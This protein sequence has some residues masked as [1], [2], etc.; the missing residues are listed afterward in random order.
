MKLYCHAIMIMALLGAI[1]ISAAAQDSIP[2]AIGNAYIS[3]IP[4]KYLDRVSKQTSSISNKID[5]KSEKLL[6]RLQK[7]EAK[8][9]R[10][11]AVVDS[12]NT[13]TFFAEA[14]QK[15]A[16]LSGKLTQK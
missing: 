16:A 2:I 6:R 4:S 5:K 11:L 9:A 14:Q 8:L 3:K 15:Y 10:I 13:K 7:R 12:A 1:Q